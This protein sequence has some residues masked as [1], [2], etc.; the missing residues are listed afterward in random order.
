V[1][2]DPEAPDAEYLDYE[3][4]TPFRVLRDDPHGITEVEEREGSDLRVGAHGFAYLNV[5]RRWV[6]NRDPARA[7]LVGRG[8]EIIALPGRTL[9]VRAVLR[10]RSDATH[11]HV[12]VRRTIL[13]G[14]ALVRTRTWSED[15]P[16]DFQ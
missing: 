16:R 10:I 7:G 14:G 11:F 5:V 9:T 2:P 3:P 4:L 15:I 12:T 6:D 8:R 1:L 13:E